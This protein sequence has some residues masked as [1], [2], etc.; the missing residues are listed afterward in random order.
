MA[1]IKLARNQRRQIDKLATHTYPVLIADIAFFEQYPDR[2]YR[3]R[4]ANDAEI[5]TAE[6]L[7]CQL[8]Q[9]PDG[10]CWFAIVKKVPGA[11]VR[12]FVAGPPTAETGLAAPD[13]LAE[14]LWEEA[15]SDVRLISDVVTPVTDG[16]IIWERM[17]GA[18]PNHFPRSREESAGST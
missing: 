16:Q 5:A 14:W 15:P 3:I 17:A 4:R 12:M 11:Y 7:D 8:L 2:R 6:L 18:D 10:W 13:R 1:D 9:P